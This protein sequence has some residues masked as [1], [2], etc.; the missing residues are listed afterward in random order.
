MFFFS[1]RVR[2]LF[3][4]VSMLEGC[5]V[6]C[7]TIC[8]F[9][10]CMSVKIKEP[11]FFYFERGETKFC[12]WKCLNHSTMRMTEETGVRVPFRFIARMKISSLCESIERYSLEY[13]CEYVS[14]TQGGNRGLKDSV[15]SSKS[16]KKLD[17]SCISNA[18]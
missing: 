8:S 12:E 10:R 4:Y 13:L 2:Y 15:E 9:R 6:I 17:Y 1:L 18:T 11:L 5:V 14:K 3:T 7:L 16:K